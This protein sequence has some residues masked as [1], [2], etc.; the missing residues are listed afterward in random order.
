[1]K[2]PIVALIC[3]SHR[4]FRAFQFLSQIVNFLL[5]DGNLE[6]PSLPPF[7]KASLQFGDEAVESFTAIPAV[8]VAP[9]DNGFRSRIQEQFSLYLPINIFHDHAERFDFIEREA[10]FFGRGFHQ[11]TEIPELLD[12]LCYLDSE[13]DDADAARG[14]AENF[15]HD[16]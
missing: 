14:D 16:D 12:A 6:A 15:C 3:Q 4:C 9:H 5:L 8:S 11:I 1:M 13:R 7:G 10:Y 2:R